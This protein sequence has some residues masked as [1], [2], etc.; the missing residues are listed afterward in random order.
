[1]VNNSIYQGETVIR[2]DTE[3]IVVIASAATW[4][5]SQAGA[6]HLLVCSPDWEDILQCEAQATT[7]DDMHIPMWRPGRGYNAAVSVRPRQQQKS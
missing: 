7:R 1:M 3:C 6:I 2:W 5:P 4:Q